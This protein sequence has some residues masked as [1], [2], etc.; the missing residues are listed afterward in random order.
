MVVFGGAEAGL[1]H[2]QLA[3]KDADKMVG[4]LQTVKKIDL[5]PNPFLKPPPVQK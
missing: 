2:A 4:Y 3:G 5:K 1:F